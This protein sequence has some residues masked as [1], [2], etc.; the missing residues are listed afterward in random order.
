MDKEE[1]KKS[2]GITA[3]TK[4]VDFSIEILDEL[5]QMALRGEELYL[6]NGRFY[7]TI[8]NF[9]LNQRIQEFFIN[10]EGS[11]HY[12]PTKSD[13]VIRTIKFSPKVKEATFDEY[14]NLINLNNG[15]L[16]LDTYEIEKHSPDQFFTYAINVKYDKEAPAPIHFGKFLKT[17]FATWDKEKKKLVPDWETVANI[18]RIG[19]YLIYPENKMERLFMFLGNGSNGKST[20]INVY[21]SFFDRKFVTSLSLKTLG[22]EEST[23]RA[24]LIRSRLNIAG[25]TKEEK[26]DAE[27]I[28]KIS[29]GQSISVKRKYLDDIDVIPR[30]KVVV[31]SNGSPFFNDTS[32]GTERR[33]FPITFPNQFLPPS[34]YEKEKKTGKNLEEKGI[35]LG[36]NEDIMMANFEKEKAGILNLF[37]GGLKELRDN[38]WHLDESDNSK[39]T[40]EDYKEQSDTLGSWLRITYR[41]PTKDDFPFPD[42]HSLI[43][44][45]TQAFH[46]WYEENYPGK[47]CM[48]SSKKIGRRIKEVFR[49][50]SFQKRM[51][52]S[53]TSAYPILKI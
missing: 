9:N 38:N 8:S 34:K 3:K 6:Y 29:S 45:I 41:E 21:S 32:Y 5:P 18:I 24:Q 13:N 14:P 12:T 20:I 44:D 47:R 30:C 25:E 22:N 51:G 37:L 42:S 40:M 27:Q 33:L 11:E 53:T 17:T 50:E 49:V 23:Q 2:F 35:I 43:G 1:K 19:G 4:L 16:N 10:H 39:E 36:I 7:E 26:I 46:N 28:K 31:D 15:V 52:T 48:Y